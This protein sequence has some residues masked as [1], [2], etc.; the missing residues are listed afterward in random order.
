M[1]IYSSMVRLVK[2]VS[3]DVIGQDPGE[4][5]LGP[6]SMSRPR[7]QSPITGIDVKDLAHIFFAGL[8]MSLPLTL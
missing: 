2:K 6:F 8:G 5:W 4:A 1:T 3:L 7:G